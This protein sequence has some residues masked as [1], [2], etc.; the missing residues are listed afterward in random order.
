MSKIIVNSAKIIENIENIDKLLK[1]HRKQ[2]T[3]VCKVLAGNREILKNILHS[4]VV[5]KIHSVAD[6]RLSGL[7]IIKDINPKVKTMLIKPPSKY[8]IPKVVRYAD[9]SLNT[10]IKMI[11]ALNREAEKIGVI[12]KVIIMIEL[13]ELREGILKENT[14]KFYSS[15]FDLKNIE[16]IGIGT[17]LGCMYGIEPDYDKL[18][19]LSLFK[20]IIELK[21]GRDL[22]VISGGSSITLPLLEQGAI[23]PDMN[24]FRVGEA[25][26]LGTT[27]YN[28]RRFDSLNEDCFKLSA[29]IIEIEKKPLFPEGRI[30]NGNIGH[31]DSGSLKDNLKDEEF[32]HKAI[33]DFGI[34]DVNPESDVKSLDKEMKFIGTTSDMTVFDIGNN[35]SGLK[36][37]DMI[38]FKPNYMGVARL[39]L[40]KYVKK[41]IFSLDDTILNS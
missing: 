6:S 31:V 12:H 39:M 13:G 29:D 8:Q 5:R 32:H 9:I 28:N 38:E 34:L 14:V 24:H 16:I 41:E 26:F 22:P 40:S 18:M 4:K 1:K 11:Q 37:G 17:N 20:K 23:P 2:L 36:V 15:V 21:F 10:S 3:L 19:Q 7:R 35:S 25:A 30:G 27:P 33:V